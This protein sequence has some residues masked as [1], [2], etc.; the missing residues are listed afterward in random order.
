MLL[1]YDLFRVDTNGKLI[2]LRPVRDMA[3]ARELLPFL[4][5]NPEGFCVIDQITGKKVRF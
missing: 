5:P 1:R 2:W 3:H 4:P